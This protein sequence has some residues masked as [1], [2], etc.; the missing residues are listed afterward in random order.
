MAQS[1][2]LN[3]P[4]ISARLMPVPFKGG[5]HAVQS[6][7]STP[8]P[9]LTLSS[10][11]MHTSS[12]SKLSTSSS[13]VQH[14]QLNLSRSASEP[15]Y[16]AILDDAYEHRH[17]TSTVEMNTGKGMI[18]HAPYL[19]HDRRPV[20]AQSTVDLTTHKGM[21]DAKIRN[22]A[23]E[24]Y[25]R[26][27]SSPRYSTSHWNNKSA[28]KSASKSMK[29]MKSGP[30]SGARSKRKDTAK[31][32]AKNKKPSYLNR[33]K[34][35]ISSPTPASS[36]QGGPNI[37][38]LSVDGM[39]KQAPNE[40]RTLHLSQYDTMTVGHT[41]NVS[42]DS[43]ISSVTHYDTSGM[44]KNMVPKT[45]AKQH[46]RNSGHRMQRDLKKARRKETAY[47]HQGGVHHDRFDYRDEDDDEKYAMNDEQSE[48]REIP[49]GKKGSFGL[50]QS[51]EE[52]TGDSSD[53]EPSGASLPLP[54]DEE[55]EKDLHLKRTELQCFYSDYSEK[56]SHFARRR[57]KE[58]TRL[59]RSMSHSRHDRNRAE[60]RY[61]HEPQP[62]L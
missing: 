4:S 29:S 22:T 61:F 8:R 25:S 47:H 13:A 26:M 60:I 62:P 50:I 44:R 37:D 10:N 58:Q 52:S 51:T 54:D 55:M 36:F 20:L 17:Q 16:S 19:G 5:R 49:R 42:V 38:V 41:P 43:Y 18:D 31:Q 57:S 33:P 9:Q 3:Q 7:I 15:F 34:L 24:D 45:M 23:S 40:E 56:R 28:S 53:S 6:P 11:S 1:P 46:P 48:S 59:S 12:I 30:K 27:S 2:A 14:N 32:K 21:L 39:L 35:P